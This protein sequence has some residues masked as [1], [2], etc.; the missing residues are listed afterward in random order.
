MIKLKDELYV[1]A[2]QVSEVSVGTYRD[3][4]NVRMK[5]GRVHSVPCDYGQSAWSTCDR[6]VKLIDKEQ[7]RGQDE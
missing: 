3:G 2:D 5:D 6:L 4:L 1:A 7:A